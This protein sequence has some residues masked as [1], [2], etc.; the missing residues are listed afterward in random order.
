MIARINVFKNSLRHNLNIVRD[1]LPQRYKILAVL[2][3]NAYNLGIKQ[4]VSAI[5]DIVDGYHLDDID[6]LIELR[7]YSNKPAYVFGFISKDDYNKLTELSAIIS[8]YSLD[9]LIELENFYKNIN[10]IIKVHIKI[11][12]LLGRMGFLPDQV[13]IL[14]DLLKNCKHVEV[15]GAY[16][17]LSRVKDDM[18]ITHTQA[19]IDLFKQSLMKLETYLER[20][21]DAHIS[22]SVGAFIPLI[23]EHEEFNMI[24]VGKVLYGIYPQQSLKK[25]VN[26]MQTFEWIS[27]V[28]QLKVL[29]SGHPIG[30][31][32][33]TTLEID[34]SIAS[35]PQGYSDGL[36]KNMGN[37][38]FVIINDQP[39]KIL[40]KTSM[41]TTTCDVSRLNG[42]VKLEDKVIFVGKSE[43]FQIS[44]EDISNK[45]NISECEFLCR[46]SRHIDRCLV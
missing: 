44:L 11:D 4:V 33:N 46:I 20:K 9:Q 6:E 17:H 15:N 29:P 34:T 19:Q 36:D 32:N 14:I 26:L 10:K 42:N 27:C 3:G 45:L 5:D 38:A 31:G 8:L 16:T 13:D 12:A 24:R 21:I 37:D 25:H 7:K 2:K 43:N 28:G 30:Y 22:S 40:G 41:N 35:I 1:T 18:D 23:H 39:C